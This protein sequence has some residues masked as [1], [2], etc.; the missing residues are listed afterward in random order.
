MNNYISIM[1]ILNK[2]PLQVWQ[3]QFTLSRTS[4]KTANLDKNYIKTSLASANACVK[5][6]SL[7]S[8]LHKNV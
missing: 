4:L 3:L 8:E 7:I 6:F 5:V 2:N 1:F